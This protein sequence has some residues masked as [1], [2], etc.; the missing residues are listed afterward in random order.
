MRVGQPGILAVLQ[1][2]QH[3][4]LSLLP[5][6][7]SLAVRSRLVHTVATAQGRGASAH[8]RRRALVH[9][10]SA[11]S[12]GQGSQGGTGAGGGGGGH[13]VAAVQAV[14]ARVEGSQAEQRNVL[15]EI[16]VAL[17]PHRGRGL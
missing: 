7:G 15:P 6:R 5:P 2:Q 17:R 16:D 1:A 9:M 11:S 13:A 4:R 10:R 3:A 8:Y 12:S 14:L